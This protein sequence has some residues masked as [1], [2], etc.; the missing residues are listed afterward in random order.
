MEK[1]QFKKKKMKID[2]SDGITLIALVVTIIV[3]LIL[4]GISI[5][6][7]AGDNGL[8]NKAAE[9]K[10][11]TDKSQIVEQARLDILGEIAGKKGENPTET[12][13]KEI[14]GTYFTSNT[15][16]EDLSDLTQKMTTK[17]GGY[18]VELSEVLNGVTI[19]QEVKETHIA[20]STEKTESYVGYYADIDNDGDVDGII[21]ADMVVG[22]T[23]S[24]RWNNDSEGWSDY[25]V[26]KIEDTTTVKDYVVSSKTYEGQTEAGKYKANDGFGEKEVLVPATN[27]KGTKDRFYV[28]ALNDFTNNSKNQFYWYYNAAGKLDESRNIETSAI[29][30]GEGK[31]KTIDMINDWNNNTAKYGDQTT[32]SSGKDYIDLWGAIQDGQYSIV[33]SATDSGKWFIPSKAEWSAFGEELGITTSNYVNKGLSD[34]YWSSSQ[35]DTNL[36]YSA[37]FLDGYMN[38]TGVSGDLYVRLST[39]F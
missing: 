5:S 4:A 23:K 38:S 21:Y 2:K 8:L 36:A 9:A 27:S 20:K 34:C 25:N 16:P 12:K 13:I 30:F 18:T 11:M 28:M 29:D 37:Y 39:T 31:Q 33:S 15:I 6:M 32:A 10:E 3:L 1:N 14:L 17:N 24:G 22:N 26:T 7:L 35:Y 19:K